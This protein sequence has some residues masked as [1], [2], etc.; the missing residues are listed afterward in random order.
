MSPGHRRHAA[1]GSLSGYS[2][3]LGGEAAYTAPVI[4]SCA[5]GYLQLVHWLSTFASLLSHS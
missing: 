3:G 2:A 5:H 1:G 4:S